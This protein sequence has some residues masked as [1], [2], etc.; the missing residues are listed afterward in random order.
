[1]GSIV[2]KWWSPLV[3]KSHEHTHQGDSQFHSGSLSSIL[4]LKCSSTQNKQAYVPVTKF[5][6]T[7]SGTFN[8]S[9]TNRLF[10]V[11]RKMPLIKCA[12][13]VLFLKDLLLLLKSGTFV[14][15]KGLRKLFKNFGSG[16][17]SS[18]ISHQQEGHTPRCLT[19]LHNKVPGNF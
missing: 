5:S 11:E 7:H 19:E 14:V 16:Y 18:P 2:Y 13:N 6:R 15:L 17:I 1:M 3:N 10:A 9:D 12:V 4:S 8:L